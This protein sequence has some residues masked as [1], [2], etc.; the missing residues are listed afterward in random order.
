MQPT[1]TAYAELQ[2][3]YDHFNAR[4][5]GGKLP[6]C[7]ITLQREKRTYG[8]FSSKRFVNRGGLLTDEIAMNPT[9]FGVRPVRVTLSTLAHEM[10]HAWQFHFG[11]P[12]RRGYHNI[13]W[14]EKMERL[15]LMP[16]NTGKPGGKRVGEQMTHFIIEGGAYAKACDELLTQEFTLSWL[17]RFPPY[18]HEVIEAI[19]GV[20][21]LS[22]MDTDDDDQVEHGIDNDLSIALLVTPGPADENK[23][24]RCKYRCPSCA[25]QVWGKPGLLVICGGDSCNRVEF[26]S[27]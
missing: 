18:T 9:Y 20:R 27:V 13:E 23:S 7:L 21:S 14:A 25:A 26:E 11:K 12:G 4:L 15:G 1:A 5:F 6:D 8:Y 10:V 22:P 16:S 19:S 3:A 24:N 2:Q 17:D